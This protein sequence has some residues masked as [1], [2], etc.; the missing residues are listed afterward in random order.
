MCRCRMGNPKKM[1]KFICL[2][3]CGENHVLDGLQRGGHQREKKH[4][5][6][7]FCIECQDITKNLEVRYCDSFDEMMQKAEELHREYYLWMDY[8]IAEME[9]KN[10]D[11]AKMIW[12]LSNGELVA[13][14]DKVQI[15]TSDDEVY[16]G[17]IIDIGETYITVEIDY[18]TGEELDVF[19][20]EL[21][22]VR[23][24]K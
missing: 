2:K 6:D 10:M 13:I 15:T 9:D 23:L 19:F 7:A 16:V 22:D 14:E 3:H 1:S 18:K 20:S 11:E 5:K 12:R 8:S 4:I 17:N 24:I 21:K